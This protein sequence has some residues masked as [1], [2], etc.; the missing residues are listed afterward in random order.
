MLYT[1]LTHQ[2]NNNTSSGSSMTQVYT[3]ISLVELKVMSERMLD[4]L[5]NAV[6]QPMRPGKNISIHLPTLQL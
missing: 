5:V 3:K 6:D 1:E 2:Y 4:D